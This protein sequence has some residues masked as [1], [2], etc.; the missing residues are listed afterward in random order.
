MPLMAAR[1]L[2]FEVAAG[3]ALAAAASLVLRASAG[4][5]AGR[6]KET[7]PH[8]FS[9]TSATAVRAFAP[10]VRLKML[11]NH[12]LSSSLLERATN[13]PSGDRQAGRLFLEIPEIR[14]V[15]T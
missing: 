8:A 13:H 7:P 6:V 1:P 5:A 11:M 2:F 15:T 12:V 4:G 3:A 10:R 14:R 9:A